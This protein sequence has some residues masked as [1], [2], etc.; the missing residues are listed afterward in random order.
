MSQ[1]WFKE[2]PVCKKMAVML[3]VLCYIA[4]CCFP[5]Y[6][7]E[8]LSRENAIGGWWSLLW[9]WLAVFVGGK[10]GF[11][12]LAWYANVTYVLSIICFLNNKYRRFYCCAILTIALGC[13]F[14]FCP[15]I[16][17]DE[18][19][20]TDDFVLAEGY[21]LWIASFAVLMIGGAACHLTRRKS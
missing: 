7:T 8:N 5:D 20:H 15:K 2:I 18:A 6:L 3:S 13:L 19:M 11:Y 21:Y 10:Y 17:V 12:F 14:S 1:V 16:I 9:G 4:A